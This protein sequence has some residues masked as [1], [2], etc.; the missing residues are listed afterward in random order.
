MW[1]NELCMRLLVYVTWCVHISFIRFIFPS[2]KDLMCIH[3]KEKKN[4]TERQC[5]ILDASITEKLLCFLWCWRIFEINW[6]DTGC[7]WNGIQFSS[8]AIKFIQHLL[9]ELAQHNKCSLVNN[10]FIWNDTTPVKVLF[11]VYGWLYF[12]HEFLH[13]QFHV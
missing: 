5:A 8:I 11:N 10:L 9:I 2:A 6:C 13:I 12:I 4:C 1:P 7:N 3:T